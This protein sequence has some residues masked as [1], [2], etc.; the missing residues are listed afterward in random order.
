MALVCRFL[1]LCHFI[2]MRYMLLFEDL[3]TCGSLLDWSDVISLL[4]GTTLFTKDT[5][6]NVNDDPI[7]DM[8]LQ[9]KFYRV[10]LNLGA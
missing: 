6:K 4:S 2:S 8:I 1:W 3:V 10:K 5:A 9:T 7:P